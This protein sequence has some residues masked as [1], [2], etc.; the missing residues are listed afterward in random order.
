MSNKYKEIGND[1]IFTPDFSSETL[2]KSL[3]TKIIFFLLSPEILAHLL[4]NFHCQYIS[5]RERTIW[6]FV[7]L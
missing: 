4:T 7:K 5:E 6:Q 1:N 3:L 2:T